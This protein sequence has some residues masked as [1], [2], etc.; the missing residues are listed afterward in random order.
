MLKVK[1]LAIELSIKL[2][3]PRSDGGDGTLFWRT[4]KLRYIERA[5]GKLMRTLSMAMRKYKPNFVLPLIP[6]TVPSKTLYGTAGPYYFTNPVINVNEVIVTRGKGIGTTLIASILAP[7]NYN[8]V[9]FGLD[10]IN[11]ASATNIF[12]CL[13]NGA[14]YL[15]PDDKEYTR[16]EGMGIEDL[17][18]LTYEIDGKDTMI[19]IDKMYSDLLITLSAIEAMNDLPN[20]QKVQLY[21]GELIDHVS[22]IA[23]YTNLME[24]REGD[25]GNG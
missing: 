17:T 8:Q 25:L 20:P 7:A 3:D 19:P 22:V 4:D 13:I 12:Y 21:R 10:E 16:I 5:Y 14:L 9:K 2:G 6:I 18:T 11:K 23:N 1:D 15:L 24:R